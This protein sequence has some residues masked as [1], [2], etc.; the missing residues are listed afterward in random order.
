MGILIV[1]KANDVA[2]K[3]SDFNAVAVIFAQRSFY[4]GGDGCALV[5]SPEPPAPCPSIGEF[6]A[7]FDESALKRFDLGLV[8]G[9]SH[10]LLVGP[11]LEP[12]CRAYQ[13]SW[14]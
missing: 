12:Q 8:L 9:F 5:P 10:P 3:V 14:F 2:R 11:P 7:D 1:T 6:G 4:P 13:C